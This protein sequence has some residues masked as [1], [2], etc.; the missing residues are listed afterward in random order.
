MAT[1]CYALLL[2]VVLETTLAQGIMKTS[3][4]PHTIPGNENGPG[5][6]P[7][8][9]E[10]ERARQSV[11]SSVRSTLLTPAERNF[12]ITA[13]CGAGQWY[14]IAFLNMSDPS[15]Q[16]PSSWREYTTGGVRACGRSFSS[17][18]SCSSTAFSTS[19][20]Q[21]SR[22]CG[23]IIGYQVG[24]TDVF[25]KQQLTIDAPYVDGVSVTHGTNTRTHIWTNVAGL[26]NHT[27]SGFESYS[28]PCAL[29]GTSFMQQIPPS[30]IGNNYYCES[31][32][33]TDVFMHS[34]STVYAD[35]PLW[36]GQQCEGQCCSNGKSPPWFSVQLPTSTS[37]NV[38]VRICGTNRSQEEDTPIKLLEIYVQ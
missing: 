17:S 28:C 8:Q 38:E 6:C 25:A 16:C 7:S 12:N 9:M 27:V 30:F 23:R 13:A 5:S 14:Q 2:F 35:D 20:R 4:P 33:P 31:G 36:D 15:Q 22:V 11:S 10:R 32:N 1:T 29:E 26:F 3:L 37:D 34:N 24:S 18:S 19:D 21:Y